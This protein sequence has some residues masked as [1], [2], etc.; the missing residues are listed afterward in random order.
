MALSPP[1]NGA[2]FESLNEEN[3]DSFYNIPG[4]VTTDYILFSLNVASDTSADISYGWAPGCVLASDGKVTAE[5]GKVLLPVVQAGLTKGKCQRVWLTIGPGVAIQN[6]KMT[7]T[8]TNMQAILEKGGNLKSMLLA[9]FGAIVQAVKGAGV[10]EVGFDMNYENEGVRFFA[11]RVANVTSRLHEQ[12][13][14]PVTFRPYQELDRGDSPWIAALRQVYSNLNRKQCVVGFNLLTYG[15][16]VGNVPAQWVDAIK[17]FKDTGVPDPADFV[18]PIISDD[19][20]APP[21][22][23]PEE[24]PQK[25]REWNAKGASLWAAS[26]RRFDQPLGP[27]W[28]DLYS[29]AI[30]KGIA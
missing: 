22:T 11:P 5:T 15:P 4:S 28:L 25:L 7:S 17:K 12:L 2:Y 9:N 21:V 13:N 3:T 16:G 29:K 14:C 1:M 30:A 20:R 6:P 24:V 10:K 18:W 19:R 27:T 23:E 26:I 8:F